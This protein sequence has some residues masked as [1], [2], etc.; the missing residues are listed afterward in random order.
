V[1]RSA[2]DT[3]HDLDRR[4][5]EELTLPED[6]LERLRLRVEFEQYAHPESTDAV[7]RAGIRSDLEALI[8]ALELGASRAERS[9]A[10]L[11]PFSLLSRLRGRRGR[12]TSAPGT[13]VP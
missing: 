8:R 3:L 5:R 7:R 1:Q 11:L 4:V 12:T 13:L 10:R 9:R 6:A 2:G